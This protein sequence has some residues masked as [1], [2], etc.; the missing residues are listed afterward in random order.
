MSF[1]ISCYIAAFVCQT[2][3][4]RF[5]FRRFLPSNPTILCRNSY[6]RDHFDLNFVRRKIRIQHPSLSLDLRHR[7]MVLRELIWLLVLRRQHTA[8]KFGRLFSIGFISKVSISSPCSGIL[9]R[10]LSSSDP[11]SLKFRPFTD[12]CLED[13]LGPACG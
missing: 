6:I 12:P 9:S 10:R 13:R 11:S 8:F 4:I 1:H 3:L 5:C 2:Y 7:R